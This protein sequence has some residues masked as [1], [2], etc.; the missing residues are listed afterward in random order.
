MACVVATHPRNALRQQCFSLSTKKIIFCHIECIVYDAG[1]PMFYKSLPQVYSCLTPVSPCIVT[2]NSN[3][4][5]QQLFSTEQQ[6]TYR[7]QLQ[8]D[9][10]NCNILL[11]MF[12]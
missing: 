5:I 10:T 6:L 9:A 12:S 3:K 7:P 4:T 1:N 2:L 8:A 11:L